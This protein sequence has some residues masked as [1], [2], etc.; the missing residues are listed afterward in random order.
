MAK[1]KHKKSKKKKNNVKPIFLPMLQTVRTDSKNIS[2]KEIPVYDF[3]SKHNLKDE[4]GLNE[5]IDYLIHY[6]KTDLFLI[7]E[8]ILRKEQ[9][10][11][12]SEIQNRVINKV[13]HLTKD[14][15]TIL[16]INNF[17]RPSEPWY[18]IVKKIVPILLVEPFKTYE[19]ISEM[20][21]DAWPEIA[22]CLENNAF[23]LSLPEGIS[24]PMDIIP[25][26]LRHKLWL[27]DCFDAIS[28]IGQQEE[29]TLDLEDEEEK[30]SWINS[31]IDSLKKNKESVEYFD[32]TLEKLLERVILPSKDEK[33]LIDCLLHELGL[34][35]VSDKLSDVL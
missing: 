11:P 10:L 25:L 23:Y 16:Y 20:Y 9:N 1:F 8:S 17:P 28:G 27:Q 26:E 32:L 29:L 3:T 12:L 31:F 21:H 7:W 13:L 2:K 14:D 24:A 22:E 15:S 6:F 5:S 19:I 34:S 4:W 33:I 30:M 35:F 18:E